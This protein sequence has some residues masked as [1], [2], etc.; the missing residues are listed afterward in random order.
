VALIAGITWWAVSGSSGT[1]DDPRLAE[2]AHAASAGVGKPAPD[3]TLSTL[4]G[5]TV[6]LSDYRG[7]PVVL[8]FWAS[9]CIPCREEFPLLRRTLA[10]HH[11]DFALIGVNTLDNIESDGRAF[12]HE[13]R[14]DWPSGFDPD[15]VV[16]RGYGVNDLP[17][18]FF[19]DRDGVV[20]SH[21]YGQL[22]SDTLRAEL[23]KITGTGKSPSS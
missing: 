14:A 10:T 17:Q 16:A 15:S 12:A 9:W 23:A 6:R 4:D 7:K 22:T 2:V 3:F 11:D 18:T 21:L 5:K 1:T 20:S 13:Q 19:I 8:N